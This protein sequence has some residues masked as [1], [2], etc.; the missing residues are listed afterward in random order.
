MAQPKISSYVRNVAKSFG[1]S[2]GD[3]FTANNPVVVSLAKETKSNAESL[4]SNIKSF[5]YDKQNIDEKAL[6]G[7]IKMTIDDAWKNLK[8]DIK[9]GNLYNKERQEQSSLQL[10]KS[11]GF[12]FDMS[13]FDFDEDWGD[14]D[15]S[16]SES[17]VM[18]SEANNTKAIISSLDEVG[19][20]LSA[21]MTKTTVES[22]D[23]IVSSANR[24]SKAL[25]NLNSR[26]FNQISSSLMVINENISSLGKIAEPLSAHMQ[27]SALF[28]TNTSKKLEEMYQTLQQISKNTTPPASALD[29][30]RSTVNNTLSD[31]YDSS[32]G[33]N[34]ES[35][36][37]MIKDNIKDSKEMVNMVVDIAKSFKS[38]DGSWGK[39]ISLAQMGLNAVVGRMIPKV[40]KDSMKNFNET[41]KYSISGAFVKGRNTSTGNIFLDLMKDFILP[42]DGFKTKLN[43][44]N[45]EKGTV[46]W[47][48]IS[49]KALT[50]VIPEALSLIYQS[51]TG[52]SWVYDYNKG[53]FIFK[54]DAIK[55]VKD[56]QRS[57]ANNAGGEFRTDALKK[58]SENKNLSAADKERLTAEIEEYFYQSFMKGEGFTD[59]FKSSFDAKKFGLNNDSL[60]ILQELIRE[61]QAKGKHSHRRFATDVQL[62][63]DSYGNYLRGKEASGTDVS[64]TLHNGSMEISQGVDG[65]FSFNPIRN[66]NKRNKKAK[67]NKTSNTTTTASSSQYNLDAPFI[68]PIEDEDELRQK[69]RED[70]VKEA[71][72][73]ANSKFKEIRG[74]I[75]DFF[76]DK[77][78][79]KSLYNLYNNPFNAASHLLDRLSLSMDRLIW[80]DDDNPEKGIMG[81]IFKKTEDFTEWLEKKFKIKERFAS[82]KNMLF[83]D[84]TEENKGFFGDLKQKTGENLKGAGRFFGNTVRQFLKTGKVDQ[85]AYGRK[86]TKDGIVAVSRGELIVPSELNPYYHG[87]TNKRAQV[88]NEQRI[89]DN[90]YGSFAEGGTV[91]EDSNT[92]KN[93]KDKAK[94]AYND[95]KGGTAYNFIKSGFDT[96]GFGMSKM[97]HGMFGTADEEQ[98]KK[99]NK[100][101]KTIAQKLLGEANENK[102]AMGAGAL[103]GAGVSVATGA[104]VGPLLGSAIGAAV[105]LTVNSKTVQHV[106]FGADPETGEVNGG[107]FSKNIS[108]FMMKKVPTISKGAM[109][110]GAAGLFMGSPILGAVLGATAGYVSSSEKAKEFIFGKVDENGRE[111]SQGLI[112]RDLQKKVKAAA[113]NIAAGALA[114]LFVGPFGILG[115]LAV[116]AGLG[117]LT[118]SSDFNKW[119]FGDKDTGEKGLTEIFKEKIFDNM[120][121][122]FHNMGNAITGWGKNLMKG[123]SDRIKDFFTKRARAF[124]NGENQTL[125]GRMIGGATTFTGKAI[126]GGTNFI[127]DRLGG[128]NRRLKARNL[129]KGYGVYDR[130]KKRNLYADERVSA[131]GDNASGTFANFDTLLAN[132]GS[133]EELETLRSQLQDARDP[134]RIFRR[135]KNAALT[136]LYSDLQELDPKKATQIA[137][138]VES[139]KTDRILSLL[140]PEEQQRYMP[141]INKAL[142]SMGS[143]QG[144][145]AR[146]TSILNSY[147]NQ[148]IDFKNVGQ[149]DSAIEQINYELKNNAKFS[150][151]QMAQKK[152]EDWRE[153]VIKIFKS[154][155]IN[156]AGLLN[157]QGG[158]ATAAESED[159]KVVQKA[160]TSISNT[161]K[162]I[163]EESKKTEIDAF[164]N[165][166]QFTKNNQGEWEE[167]KND[168]DTDESRKQIDTFMNS[169]NSIPL[170]GSGLA[171][172][173]GLFKGMHDKLFG[174]KEN[175]KEGLFGK[176]FGFLSGKTD[177]PLSYLFNFLAG[178][179][180]IGGIAKSALSQVTLSNVLGGIVAPALGLGL[181][182]GKMNDIVEKIGNA[183]IFKGNDSKSAFTESSSY[184]IDGKQL[185]TDE[186][187]KLIKDEK[188]NYQT[189]DGEYIN[190]IIKQSGTNTD[191]Q[192][193]SIKNLLNRKILGIKNTKSAAETLLQK[194][195]DTWKKVI[196][197]VTGKEVAN[198]SLKNGIMKT[199]SELLGKIPTVI[200]HIPFLPDA[201]KD[202]IDD[203]I[204]TIYTHLDDAVIKAGS[205]LG[206]IA[207]KLGSFLVAIKIP[208]IIAKGIDA[209][210]NAETILGITEEATFGQKVIAT[211]VAL[212]NAS[213]PVIG[214]LIP[215]KTLVNI[216]MTIAPKIGIDVSDLAQQR[217]KAEQEALE[218]GMSIEE[219]NEQAGRDSIFS[220]MGNA[221]KGIGTNITSRF[222]KRQVNFKYDRASMGTV[223]ISAMSSPYAAGQQMTTRQNMGL[224]GAGSGFISQLD[225]RYS[226]MKFGNF[227][228]G[229]KGCAPAVAAMV[230]NRFGKKLSMED[231]ISASTPYQNNNG[232]SADYFKT[233]LNSRGINTSYLQGGNVSEQIIQRLNNGEQ[234]ILL[235]QDPN[236][237]SKDASPFGP[238]G[239]YVVATGID[240]NGNIIIND[241][242]SKQPKKYSRSILT[243]AKMGISTK[244]SGGNSNTY[245]SETARAVWGFFT[246]NGFSPAATAGIMGNI[247]QESKMNP[248]AIQNN[249]SGPAAGLFQWEN[250]KTQSGRWKAMYDYANSKGYTWT[251]LTPQLEYALQELNSNDINNRFSKNH[252]ITDVDGQVYNIAGIGGTSAFKAATDPMKAVEQFEAAFERAGKPRFGPRKQAAEAYYKLYH[253]SEYTGNYTP[254]NASFGPN[255]SSTPTQSGASETSEQK[256]G[257]GSILSAIGTAFTTGLGKAFGKSQESSTTNTTSNIT[258]DTTSSNVDL[259]NVPVGK[260]NSA[261]KKIVQFAQSRVGK[262]QYTQDSS[263]RSLV[264][265]GYS[266]CSSFAQWAYKQ[267]LGIDPGS[268]TGAQIQSP[269]LT[270][271]DAGTTPNKERLEAGDL[272]FFASKSNNGRY[273]NVGHVEIYDGNGN[274]I[275]HGSGQ[276]PKVRK[277]EDYVASRASYGGP[278]IE[279]RRYTDIA[280]ASGGSSGLLLRSRPG[281]S[282]YGTNTGTL[283]V[284]R[285]KRVAKAFNGGATGLVAETT[286]ML[287]NL[288]STVEAKGKAG[289]IS[290][291]LVEKLL[292]SIIG[293]L[294]T[295]ATNTTSV[296]RIYALLSTYFEGGTPKAINTQT[297]KPTSSNNNFSVPKEI[298]ANIRNLTE[299]IMAIAK[300]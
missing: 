288:K 261:Q 269:L 217:A 282:V 230:A 243:K 247:W 151:E 77:E 144:S 80:G 142:K 257:I 12:D 79:P 294:E 107:L 98:T 253:N 138:L 172:V 237:Q 279:A 45:Y 16:D 24:S 197:K 162:S 1:Y 103:I 15:E 32:T 185:A 51:M 203:I 66:A 9:T 100:I 136:Q 251:Q 200:K 166:H 50:E 287:N 179:S 220:K 244:A 266:D 108:E 35:L 61:N 198:L 124:Q 139:G 267:A 8:D 193:Q 168:S 262:N 84:G 210:G 212:V 67:K 299:T 137:K 222:K 254:S 86:V 163:D 72:N 204:T 127:G 19:Y 283:V 146:A 126:K 82:L 155:D 240:Q 218:S 256:V 201:I 31:I 236:N 297:P 150:P 187:G 164:G 36:K 276:G 145:K 96:L 97:I 143:A 109:L 141:A 4:Y 215:N 250:Y 170:I 213:I 208:Y 189:V 190:G 296:E 152:E 30:K 85:A 6:K 40:F 73:I 57:Y 134:N 54:K 119:M 252:T 116:G 74:K 114:G 140:T 214:D 183:S 71:K 46:A 272:L 268:Y 78:N 23:Y 47:D 25:Y 104:V 44:S 246:Q 154:M 231:A 228:V 148:G 111:L 128:I 102:G 175:K 295:I 169:V 232:T 125:L 34:I 209:W 38:E 158:N 58:I 167:Q 29:G 92:F 63:R 13:D 135:N 255:V 60:A 192:T 147:K 113:P 88:R 105:G 68:E 242:E 7:Q 292:S 277:L 106:L 270:T 285:N 121:E 117:F 83:G 159:Q 191:A 174:D 284:P 22:A 2:L 196:S 55:A 48:G 227:T 281:S 56:E 43:T 101:I 62:Q 5:K 233:V 149:I 160:A 221:V 195:T 110:G 76:F 11:L 293:I 182:T 123:T 259:S 207:T 258:G 265:K 248:Q 39:N 65:S 229:E 275:G 177:G 286:S 245:D 161:L 27:N 17:V 99:D 239:H 70:K 173:G 81:Y 93:V 20:K 49:R 263:L 69:E 112:S 131:R 153:R 238:N 181:L 75:S 219:I 224:V 216:F 157:K 184:T 241:P 94:S 249:G 171:S 91:G 52:V 289:T 3:V 278:Y 176:L 273:K 180:V 18:S 235:G 87:P 59:I 264:D 199:I 271:V 165:I 120:D 33:I 178:K 42:Q 274:V 291:E 188:G 211:M 64:I 202:N 260:G 223:N 10:A 26:G 115:N 298:D 225:P 132:A 89:I 130:T 280:A 90:F 95:F 133:V 129:S 300:G 156:I 205:K 118:T 37:S 194:G 290:T 28:Y 41:L 186:N 226:S 53:K 21:S 234:V 14:F 122:I 206:S